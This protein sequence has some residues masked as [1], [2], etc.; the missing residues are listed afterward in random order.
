MRCMY[1]VSCKRRNVH[2]RKKRE[3]LKRNR[4]SERN[5]KDWSTASPPL[6]PY[7]CEPDVTPKS[8]TRGRGAPISWEDPTAVLETREGSP[9]QSRKMPST[10]H[11]RHTSFGRRCLGIEDGGY[12]KGSYV[13]RRLTALG[14]INQPSENNGDS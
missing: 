6:R 7:P 3:K 11:E 4:S 12:G 14:G 5:Q 8:L 9:S 13:Q 1:I 2:F 10:T